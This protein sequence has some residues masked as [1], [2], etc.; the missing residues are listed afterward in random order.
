MDFPARGDGGPE[1]QAALR[2]L[3]ESIANEPGLVWKIWTE[4]RAGG[5]AGGIYLFA[6]LA[7]ARAYHAMHAAR[8]T[9]QGIGPIRAEYRH[10]N[11]ALSA[12]T[13]APITVDRG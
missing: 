5:R 2:A 12:I 6:S 1:Q 3:A 7:E 4:D 8:L 10:A 11:T 13:R 9:E